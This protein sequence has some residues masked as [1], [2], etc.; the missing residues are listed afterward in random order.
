MKRD[1]HVRKGDLVRHYLK[2][3]L[4][5]VTNIEYRGSEWVA[6]CRPLGVEAVTVR[7]FADHVLD[8]E[9]ACA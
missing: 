7:Y 9:V 8:K 5:I 1:P 2:G 3:G 6:T 4:Y